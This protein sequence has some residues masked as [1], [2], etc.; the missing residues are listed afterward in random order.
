M[1]WSGGIFTRIYNWYQEYLDGYDI[2]PQKFDGEDDNFTTGIN[3]CLTK[4]GQNAPDQDL[5]MAGNRHTNVGDA[6]NRNEY[7][8]VGQYQDGWGVYA[9]DSTGDADNYVVSLNPNLT[10][11]VEGMRLWFKAHVNCNAGADLNVNTV[12]VRDLEVGGVAVLAD[13]IKA[14][15]IYGIFYTGTAWQ[16]HASNANNFLALSDTPEDYTGRDGQGLVVNAAED[17]LE[18]SGAGVNTAGRMTQNGTHLAPS[19]GNSLVFLVE[20]FDISANIVDLAGDKFDIPDDGFYQ[21]HGEFQAW[22]PA[23]VATNDDFVELRLEVNSVVVTLSRVSP[24]HGTA[25]STARYTPQVNALLELEAGDTVE[26]IFSTNW[27][28]VNLLNVQADIW[29]VF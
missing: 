8:V 23:T 9:G 18:F 24:T 12:G 16:V 6:V 13:D 22:T 14:G 7:L 17:A 11:Y 20:E 25:G 27:S 21:I 3:N 4:D 5:P 1:P 28:G 29:Q 19:P 10:A 26:F 2:D 15:N